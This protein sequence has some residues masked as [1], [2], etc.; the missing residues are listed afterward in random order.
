MRHYLTTAHAALLP[1]LRALFRSMQRH[2]RP[3][4][5][6]LMSEGRDVWDWALD[7][8]NEIALTAVEGFLARRPELERERMDG[9]LRTPR[10]AAITRRWVLASE[11]LWRGG[12]PL[13]VIDTD[14]LFFSSPEPVFAE[15]AH[16][17]M[18]VLPHGFAPAALGRPGA[19]MESHRRYGL[20]NAGWTYFAHYDPA[21][22]FAQ[23]CREGPISF[24]RE[25][26][27][28][29]TRWGEQGSL[30]V[31]AEKHGAHVIQ[32]PAVAPGPWSIHAHDL[33]VRDNVVFF[34]GRPLVS[35]HYHSRRA[36][37]LAN[38]EYAVSPRQAQILYA[39]YNRA[40]AE[41][42]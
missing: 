8:P 2:C 41:S 15:I 10:E 1:Q 27:D 9:P 25:H 28:G 21:A 24:D 40:L 22:N 39:P 26:A 18:A 19:T 11:I 3:F 31:V 34:G 6:H 13:T 7:Q 12:P 42:R 29:T 36:D 35:Y 30:E 4:T 38:P 14:M 5:L 20:Y 17:R 16:A 37:Q 32:H 33:E 23:L